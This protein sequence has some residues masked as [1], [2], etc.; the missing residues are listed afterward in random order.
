MCGRSRR[1]RRI[2]ATRREPSRSNAAQALNRDAERQAQEVRLRAERKTGEL[3][4]EGQKNG[5]LRRQGGT[6][7]NQHHEQRSDSTT[8]AKALNDLG[9][10]KDQSSQ[11]QKL[12]EI[13]EEA[14][15]NRS[16]VDRLRYRWSGSATIG[17]IGIVSPD[18][19]FSPCMKGNSSAVSTCCSAFLIPV[20]DVP[21]ASAISARATS[22]FGLCPRGFGCLSAFCADKTSAAFFTSATVCL[23]ALNVRPRSC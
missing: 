10:S 21:I 5:Q 14:T 3:I 1:G 8:S 6:G 7:A 18:S 9:I 17:Q 19:N 2:F 4:A 15:R 11:W 13:P 20:S 12:A 23:A 22:C 16:R